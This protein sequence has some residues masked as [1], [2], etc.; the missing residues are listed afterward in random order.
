MERVVGDYSAF[1]V[2]ARHHSAWDV[3][4]QEGASDLTRLVD[5]L[6]AQSA[7]C[8]AIME[9]YR[10]LNLLDGRTETAGY[11]D[12]IESGIEVEFGT[13][14]L[15]SSSKVLLVGSGSFPM[16]PLYIAKRTG[17]AVVGVDID[18]EAV[19]LGRRV[20]K[21]LGSDLDIRLER[22]SLEDLAFTGEASHIIFSSTVSVKYALLDSIHPLT[23]DDVVVAIRY[24][25]HLK[26][27]FNYPMEDVDPRKWKAVEQV[28]RPEHIFDVALYVKA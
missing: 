11:F 23:R 8:A 13:F 19:E 27:L 26:S 5:E 9:K 16:T 21:T 2:D 12:N 4:E 24:G 28:L 6:R 15:T 20:V 18:E 25:D 17:A 22:S 7:R 1:V 14:R 3:L 10:A